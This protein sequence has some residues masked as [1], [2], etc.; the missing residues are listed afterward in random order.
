MLQ[1]KQQVESLL[2]RTDSILSRSSGQSA[3]VHKSLAEA[4]LQRYVGQELA[5]GQPQLQ[6]TSCSLVV[7]H[8][9]VVLVIQQEH[10]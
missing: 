7:H 6:S 2:Q 9:R 3:S 10:A 1:L 5:A 8:S 4:P